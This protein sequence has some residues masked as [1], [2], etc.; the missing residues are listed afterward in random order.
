MTPKK[1]KPKWILYSNFMDW[2]PESAAENRKQCWLN[3][4]TTQ[5]LDGDVSDWHTA[6]MFM[7]SEFYRIRPYSEYTADMRRGELTEAQ[8]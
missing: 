7:R 2:M 5:W 4:I 8:I 3:G 6:R 1:I